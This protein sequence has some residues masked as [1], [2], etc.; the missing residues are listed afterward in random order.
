[1]EA[2][3]SYC[4]QREGIFCFVY[5]YSDLSCIEFPCLSSVV[6]LH[7]DRC[8]KRLRERFNLRLGQFLHNE[9]YVV[10]LAIL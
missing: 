3:I 7:G 8:V 6:F 10:F 2:K 5:F 4:Q 1:M 9:D